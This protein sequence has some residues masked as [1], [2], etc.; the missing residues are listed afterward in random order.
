MAETSNP[1]HVFKET[2]TDALLGESL[3]TNEETEE[4]GSATLTQLRAQRE[5]LESASGQ[6]QDTQRVTRDARSTLKHI[7]WK[8]FR[9]KLTLVLARTAAPRP[10]LRRSDA[11]FTRA[12]PAAG[13]RLHARH[14]LRPRIP[15]H[16][17]QRQALNRARATAGDATA[18]AR[19]SSPPVLLA[20]A[21]IYT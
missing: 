21:C 20:S 15:P 12:S 19:S 7:A 4:I 8:V 11:S 6:A 18:T 13:H 5:Q 1:F 17:A 2:K 14:R 3:R 10:L 16:H 9:E